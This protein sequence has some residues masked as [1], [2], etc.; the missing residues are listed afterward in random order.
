MIVFFTVLRKALY[1]P[2]I[3]FGKRIRS[4]NLLGAD[5]GT[6]SKVLETKLPCLKVYVTLL[7]LKYSKM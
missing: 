5:Y 3:L 6:G 2:L 1:L 7:T 4:R